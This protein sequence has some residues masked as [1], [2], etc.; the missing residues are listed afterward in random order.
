MFSFAKGKPRYSN[1]KSGMPGSVERRDRCPRSR[2]RLTC[3][4]AEPDLPHTQLH[5]V[6]VWCLPLFGFGAAFVRIRSEFLSGLLSRIARRS[7]GNH[8]E[9]TRLRGVRVLDTR[10]VRQHS[11]FGIR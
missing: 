3:A 10:S 7:R 5:L 4:D 8:V 2:R 1:R 11:A 9:F 6:Q